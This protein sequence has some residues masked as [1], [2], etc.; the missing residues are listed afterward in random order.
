[1]FPPARIA[2]PCAALGLALCA[3]LAQAQ[4]GRAVQSDGPSQAP[5]KTIHLDVAALDRSGK[6]V[7]DLR[8]HEFEVW[9]TGY[10]V[11]IDS[12][13][14]VTPGPESG[15]SVLLVLDD[16]AVSPQL[17]VRVKETARHFVGLMGPD[18]HMAVMRLDGDAMTFTND[19]V[20]L[21]R[22]IDEYRVRSVPMRIDDAGRHVLT[23]IAALARQLA[24]APGRR[25]TIV[26]IGAG[27]L[28]D[29]P[30]PSTLGLADL[31]NEWVDAMRATAS[32]N[33]ALYV[34]DPGGLG[35]TTVADAGVSGF[36]RETGGHAYINTN[37]LTGAAESIWRDAGTH[38]VLSVKD[39]PFGRKLE[40][41]EVDV[42]VLRDGVRVRARRGI[43]PK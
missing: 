20:P 42:K 29:R 10:R 11:P 3:V 22:A 32:S 17:E 37:D 4:A 14:F 41:R 24:E 35:V 39:P 5:A 1:M 28:F 13:R 31:R 21:R 15:R 33:V 8:P 27:W 30:I 26:A 36:A 12:V 16:L 38:Y 18:D 7:V 2:R 43:G 25:K 34:I 40:L 9:I 6:P 19:P 23:T